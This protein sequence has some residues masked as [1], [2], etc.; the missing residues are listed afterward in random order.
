MFMCKNKYFIKNEEYIN[1]HRNNI[2]DMNQF[3]IQQPPNINVTNFVFPNNPLSIQRYN[4]LQNR[5]N[6]FI[7]VFYCFIILIVFLYSFQII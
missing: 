5:F 7:I 2:L 3:I 4:N 6:I 1:R